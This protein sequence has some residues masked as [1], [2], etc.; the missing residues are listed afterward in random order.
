VFCGLVLIVCGAAAAADPAVERVVAEAVRELADEDFRSREAATSALLKLGLDAI[1]VLQ[2]QLEKTKDPE[3]RRRIEGVIA[4]IQRSRPALTMT[5]EPIDKPIPLDP[6]AFV[7]LKIRVQNVS[8]KPVIVCKLQGTVQER[9]VIRSVINA[10]VIDANG[11]AVCK[12]LQGPAHDTGASA[13]LHMTVH[14]QAGK[15]LVPKGLVGTRAD[16]LREAD[17]VTVEPGKDQVFTIK[18]PVKALAVDKPGACELAVSYRAQG[19]GS[20]TGV[21]I[22]GK[23]QKHVDLL[24]NTYR[25]DVTAKVKLVFAAR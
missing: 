13:V 2:A 11:N 10:F 15:D 8:T 14:D 9:T 23:S 19:A 18:V 20:L 4:S 25:C 12:E 3:V 1:P 17:F 24:L 7:E 22:E 16:S 6:A 21:S 5:V